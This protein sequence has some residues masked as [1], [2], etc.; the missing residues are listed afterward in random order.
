MVFVYFG[1]GLGYILIVFGFDL[2]VLVIGLFCKWFGCLIIIN[3]FFFEV[4]VVLLFVEI[5]FYIRV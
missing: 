4:Y 3:I 2:F 5:W 1:K